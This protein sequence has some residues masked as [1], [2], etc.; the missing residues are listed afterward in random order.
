MGVGIGYH[1]ELFLIFDIKVKG[2]IFERVWL[3]DF[4]F[5]IKRVCE[6]I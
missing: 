3:R 6:K 4:D 5:L 1:L 2:L